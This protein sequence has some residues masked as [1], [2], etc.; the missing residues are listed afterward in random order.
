MTAVSR[1]GGS[2]GADTGGSLPAEAQAA[3]DRATRSK[4]D[5]KGGIIPV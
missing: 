1:S 5:R 3:A 2:A 4:S